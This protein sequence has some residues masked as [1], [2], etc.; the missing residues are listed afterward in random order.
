[1]LRSAVVT[2]SV[3]CLSSETLVY[4]DK[5]AELGSHGF[6]DEYLD[7]EGL[8]WV[9]DFVALLRKQCEIEVTINHRYCYIWTFSWNRSF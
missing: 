3:V 5:T 6:R 4:C 9:F 7:L 8:K 2:M 1:M